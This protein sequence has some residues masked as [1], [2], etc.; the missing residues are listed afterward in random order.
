MEILDAVDVPTGIHSEGDPIQAAMAHH[1]G[2]AVG[3][4][5]LPS[6]SE[7]PFHDG[8]RTDTALLQCVDIAGFT[9]GFL[10]HC[11][12]RLSPQLVVAHHAGEALHVEDLVHGRA[13]SAFPN[14]I[15][16][17]AGTAAKVVIRGRILHVI[18]HFLGQMFQ[19]ILRPE[20][21]SA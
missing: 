18:Q 8:L 15:L 21:R 14:N 17:T 19:L 7:N 6:G 10:L 12:E 5:G 4:V 13:A 2:E 9:V 1:T 11:V 20:G 3:M 16:P